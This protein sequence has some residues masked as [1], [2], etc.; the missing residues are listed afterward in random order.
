MSTTLK[1][2]TLGVK[3]GVLDIESE[4]SCFLCHEKGR[5]T[6]PYTDIQKLRKH[7]EQ[8]HKNHF[9]YRTYHLGLK[10]FATIEKYYKPRGNRHE[11]R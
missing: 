2:K 7:L 5:L 3:N 4:I 6:F 1:F 10:K 11:I 9:L 8:V